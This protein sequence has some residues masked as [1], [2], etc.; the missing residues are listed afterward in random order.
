MPDT[1]AILANLTQQLTPIIKTIMLSHGLKSNSKL[2]NSIQLE[3]DDKMINFLINDYF[4]YVSTGRKSGGKKV[5][6]E[7]IIQF[8]KDNNLQPRPIQSK[9]LT[10]RKSQRLETINQLA[11]AIQ[12]SIY[13]QGIQGKN[14]IDEI[15]QTMTD[16][17]AAN[18]ADNY[19]ESIADEITANLTIN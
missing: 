17:S 3:S 4:E 11:F 5:P 10:H 6:I 14:Y 15:I 16:I 18:I 7:A 9:A 2:I 12:T 13:K 1:A 8:I 19:T